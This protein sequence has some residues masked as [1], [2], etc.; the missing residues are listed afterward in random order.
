MVG[1]ISKAICFR[2]DV[3][4]AAAAAAV[5]GVIVVLYVR[6]CYCCTRVCMIERCFCCSCR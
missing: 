2:T 4:A 6:M 3:V 1:C 5:V